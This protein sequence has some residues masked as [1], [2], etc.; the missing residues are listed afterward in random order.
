M[1]AAAGYEVPVGSNGRTGDSDDDEKVGDDEENEE[2]ESV[3]SDRAAIDVQRRRGRPVPRPVVDTE[4]L[5]YFEAGLVR[6]PIADRLY[7]ARR[8]TSRSRFRSGDPAYRVSGARHVGHFHRMERDEQP[9]AV[10]QEP[11]AADPALRA[12]VHPRDEWMDG[13]FLRSGAATSL[14]RSARDTRR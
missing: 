10:E 4:G 13:A 14:S 2:D 12:G 11:S 7:H 3:D 9:D 6:C 8:T 5:D 1:G